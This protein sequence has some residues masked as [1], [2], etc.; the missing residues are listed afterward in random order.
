MGINPKSTNSVL[1]LDGSL[2]DSVLDDILKVSNFPQRTTDTD[3]VT[4]TPRKYL[5]W[6]AFL[7]LRRQLFHRRLWRGFLLL[8]GD[9]PPGVFPV[10]SSIEFAGSRRCQATQQLVFLSKMYVIYAC[11]AILY[12]TNIQYI[13]QNP[14]VHSE[15]STENGLVSPRHGFTWPSHPETPRLL[16]LLL[17]V[18]PAVR[19]AKAVE[20]ENLGTHHVWVMQEQAAA[21]QALG[22]SAFFL[23]FKRWPVASPKLYRILSS[24]ETSPVTLVGFSKKDLKIK[25]S[26]KS[27][28]YQ[29][30]EKYLWYFNHVF[31]LSLPVY[32]PWHKEKDVI[33]SKGFLGGPT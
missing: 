10:V 15:L 27:I 1:F 19:Q 30:R 22:P 2:R 5:T 29:R 31:Y 23:S 11:N 26:M 6:P 9:D 16:V 3:G 12:H 32:P 13:L 4:T 18:G 24:G 28:Q 20:F 17:L 8:V 33:F 7:Q 14:K 25:K 21:F